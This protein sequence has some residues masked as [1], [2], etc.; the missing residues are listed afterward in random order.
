MG[1]EIGETI[2]YF[3]SKEKPEDIAILLEDEC[4]LKILSVRGTNRES[5]MPSNKLATNMAAT[6][7][8]KSLL[9]SFKNLSNLR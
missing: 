2:L 9:W 6:A 7:K 3:K 4:L 1:K 8:Q 5:W